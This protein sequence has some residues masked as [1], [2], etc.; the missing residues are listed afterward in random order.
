MTGHNTQ[1]LYAT[2]L[3]LD[4]ALIAPYGGRLVQAF[5]P[6]LDQHDLHARLPQ[7]K[8]VD[9]S[10]RELVDLEM[11][12]SGAYSPLTGYMDKCT[13]T[14][15]LDSA[16]LPNGMPW[17]L[18]ITLA[19]TEEV[20]KSLGE[21]QGVAL[22][23][24]DD[25]VGVM[26]I[27]DIFPWDAESEVRIF[28]ES[29]EQSSPQI[30][31]RKARKVSYLLGGV[32]SMLTSRSSER[33]L[34]QHQWPK[35]LHN[36]QVQK[37]W[38]KIAA[39]HLQNPWQ[40]SD[41]YLLKCAL[42]A[43]DALL[44]HSS[45][46]TAR[47]QGGLLSSVLKG[48]SRLLLENY[49]PSN[50][51]LE[52]PAPDGFFHNSARA[53]LQHAIFSQNYGCESIFLPA[54]GKFAGSQQDLTNLFAEARKH[55]LTIRCV[56]LDQ[57]FHCDQCGCIA[58]EKSCPHNAAGRTIFSD[59]EI[60]AQLMRGKSL[61]PTVA[62]P[63]VARAV[64]RGMANKTDPGDITGKYLYPHVSEISRDL[65]ESMAGHK[66]GVLWMTGMSGSGKSTIAHRIERELILS[67][68]RV[69]VLDGDTLRTGL[70]SDLGFGEEARRENLRRAAEVA[71][72]L[73]DAGL[74]VIASFIS[75]FSAERQTVRKIIGAGFF[76]VY[77]EA[78]LETCEERDPKGLY[79]RARAG[80]IPNFTG[81]SSPYD[82]PE[83]PD[84]RLNTSQ[85]SL[86]ECVRQFHGFIA[87]SELLR[88]DS[89]GRQHSVHKESFS[90]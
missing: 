80:V 12:A 89:H 41:E 58:T 52:N 48:A 86:D 70:N 50:R 23:H 38:H 47:A 59:T 34:Q 66:A 24:D 14:S 1:A 40:R 64:A 30:A 44:L 28:G 87:Q 32:V 77:V 46:E 88:A 11:I 42:E 53:I 6:K 5:V 29:G 10:A 21:G 56:F 25:V 19:A 71:K 13:Y 82:I 73:V 55:G 54:Q 49:I 17:G 20:A 79:K 31:E 67:G 8:R 7:L 68:H 65:I 81:I 62:R 16:V 4:D 76:E 43:S 60:A 57:P 3:Q 9:I 78:T 18:P 37:Q 85:H 84:L 15:V 90:A 83:H 26:L 61:P 63:D 22:Y 27:A 51:V 35:D 45:T 39:I 33:R 2:T 69:Y 74:I 72:V 75:P 36:L